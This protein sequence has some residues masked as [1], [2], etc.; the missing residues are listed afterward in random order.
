MVTVIETQYV[1]VQETSTEVVSASE[2]TYLADIQ[3]TIF[4]T[5]ASV[6]TV[7]DPYTV[8]ITAAIPGQ[9]LARRQVHDEAY[10][11]KVLANNETLHH[12]GNVA[13]EARTFVFP[14]RPSENWFTNLFRYNKSYLQAQC[15]SV[16]SPV[17]RGID[18]VVIAVIV[19]DR[20]R[21]SFPAGHCSS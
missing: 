3:Q 13:L 11:M 12:A 7:R 20:Y 19:T 1:P 16:A 15:A 6:L 8:T 21:K 9:T 10:W 18:T 2:T 14:S 4:E 5:M 17:S